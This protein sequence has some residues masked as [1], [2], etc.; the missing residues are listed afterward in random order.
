MTQELLPYSV[1][2]TVYYKEKPLFLRMSLDSIFNQTYKSN[3]V[4]LVCDG[5][6]T[7]ELDSAI[8]EYERL[9]SS[10]L[11][12]IRLEKNVGTGKARNAGLE[13][14]KNDYVAIMD[15]DDISLPTRCFLQMTKITQN[16]DIAILGG[17]MN[18]FVGSPDN[19]VAVKTVPTGR[20]SIIKYAKKRDPFNNNTVIIK[21][22]VALSVGGYPDLT[23]CED[24]ML[25]ATMLHKGFIG[26]N[27]N[28]ILSSYRLADDTY[29]RRGSYD[30]LKGFIGVRWKIHRMGFS[31]FWDFLFPC[32][33]QCVYTILPLSLKKRLYQRVIRQQMR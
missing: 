1:L 19:I 32:C 21:R 33:V 31:S 5:P 30:S 14:C 25:Y 8:E 27:L 22:D 6:L 29:M 26:E 15:S 23:R 2:M 28:E 3:D 18:E 16:S 24:Y 17:Q 12:V 7:D 20:D 4:V 11:H 10:V 13:K 9:F